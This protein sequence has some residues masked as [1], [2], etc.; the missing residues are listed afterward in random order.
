MALIHEWQND[1]PYDPLC[2]MNIKWVEQNLRRLS[3]SLDGFLPPSAFREFEPTPQ[4]YDRLFHAAEL[5]S[6]ARELCH[7][8]GLAVA[9]S[10]EVVGDRDDPVLDLEGG[11]S[12]FEKEIDSAGDYS[13]RPMSDSRIRIG[14]S[15]FRS[16]NKLGHVL[17]H[18]ITHH[19][20]DWKAIRPV[21]KAENEMLT[22]LLAV[23][24]GFG[25]LV[26][27]G[28]A[29]EPPEASRKPVHIT[30]KGVPYLGYPLLAYSYWHC[31][32]TSAVKESN[33]LTNVKDPCATMVEAFRAR[34]GKSRIWLA[35]LELF[36]AI[37]PLP[38]TDGAGL[39]KDAWRLDPDRH[40][41]I[42]CL[43][44]GRN[45]RIPKTESRLAITCPHCK[46]S[47]TV[48]TRPV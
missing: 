6:A 2:T 39:V 41:I 9:P 29:D 20:A 38:D 3:D 16:P 23:Y 24:L 12:F 45:L 13:T 11:R 14:A 48:A 36:R 31:Q 44:C 5:N 18:E 10:V 28:A 22:D 8:I 4:F 21:K 15:H 27:N 25:K 43:G 42:P 47:F 1:A 37:P 17:A 26:L 33:L 34:R 46:K 19:Y 35:L 7:H 40:R 32:Q 30:E